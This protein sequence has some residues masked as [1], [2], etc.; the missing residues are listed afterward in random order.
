[1]AYVAAGRY[2]GFWERHLNAWDLAAGVIIVREAGGFIEPLSKGGDILGDGAVI[3]ANEPL[4]DK[5]AKTIRG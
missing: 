2:D 5:F 4:F 3:C 1:M